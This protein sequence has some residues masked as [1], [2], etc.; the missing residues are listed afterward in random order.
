VRYNQKYRKTAKGK[1]TMRKQRQNYI[2]KYPEKKLTKRR[3]R[4]AIR[5]GR[6][7]VQPCEV[8]GRKDAVQAHHEDYSKPLAVRWLCPLHHRQEDMKRLKR[9][10]GEMMITSK[11]K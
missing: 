3:V 8:C 10:K 4:K 1:I 2:K 7:I 6:L 11:K 9:K 5:E